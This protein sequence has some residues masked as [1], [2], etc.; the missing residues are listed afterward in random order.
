MDACANG[1]I[2]DEGLRVMDTLAQIFTVIMHLDRYLAALLQAYGYWVYALLFLI[3]FAETGFVVTPVLPG[4]SLLF[5]CGTLAGSGIMEGWVLALLLISAAVLGD[6]ANYFIG[7]RWGLR[8]FAGRRWRL[9]NARHLQLTQDFYGRHGGKTVIIARFLPIIRTFAPF[10]AGL[11][12][13]A[14]G[15]FAAFNAV[16]AVLW[17][18][19]LLGAGYFLGHLRWFQENLTMALLGIILISLLPAFL[20]WLRHRTRLA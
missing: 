14:Y 4:D 13:M 16:G 3:I 1:R 8:L 10:V 12:A 2:Q 7:R 6:A 5:V 9:L 11:A 20:A 19:G 17:V 15:R 18:G